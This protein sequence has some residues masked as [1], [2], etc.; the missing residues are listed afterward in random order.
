MSPGSLTAPGDFA[1]PGAVAM[2]ITRG[3]GL[4]TT[5]QAAEMVR[6]KP[7]TIRQWKHRGHLE[8]AGLDEHGKPLYRPEDVYRAEKAVRDRSIRTNG[9]DPRRMRPTEHG[10]LAA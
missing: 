7:G 6:K 1:Y 8:P 5:D 4:V 10:S 3:D 2:F 9:T